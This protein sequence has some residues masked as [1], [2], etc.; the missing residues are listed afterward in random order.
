MIRPLIIGS[1]QL[2]EKYSRIISLSSYFPGKEKH[3]FLDVINSNH[4]CDSLSDANVVFLVGKN[5]HF[6]ELVSKWVKEQIP[7]YFTEVPELTPGQWESLIKL[8]KES[9][10]LFFPELIV[11]NH[12][13]LEEFINTRPG[14][15]KIDYQQNLPNKQGVR[16]ALAEAFALVTLLS[17]MPV[18]KMNVNTQQGK[19]LEVGFSLLDHSEGT[20]TI[21]IDRKAV[22]TIDLSWTNNRFQFN[23]IDGYVQNHH[24]NQFP[25]LPW[26]DEKLTLAAVEKFALSVITRQSRA[27]DIDRYGLVCNLIRKLE[28]FLSF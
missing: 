17:P 12:P 23:L 22:H 3:F 25:S 13:L 6:Y 19:I 9:D 10:S 27:I 1:P 15:L 20:I 21:E 8:V 26:D 5:E 4:H 11:L 14:K 2:T 16:Q 28:L 18:K 24:G 7:V